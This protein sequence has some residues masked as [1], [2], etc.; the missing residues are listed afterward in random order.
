MHSVC[1][2]IFV[3]FYGIVMVPLVQFGGLGCRLAGR[4][5]QGYNAGVQ[6]ICSH[7]KTRG[8]EKRGGVGYQ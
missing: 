4:M 5:L 8:S 6:I 2:V 1:G 3:G 7:V